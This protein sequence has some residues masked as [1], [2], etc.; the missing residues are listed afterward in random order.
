[1]M[2]CIKR[3]SPATHLEKIATTFSPAT[4]GRPESNDDRRD[5][6]RYLIASATSVIGKSL[7]SRQLAADE[8]INAGTFCMDAALIARR[9]SERATANK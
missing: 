1:M 5:R 9:P 3:V 8:Q 2:R 6:R 4:C 7:Q